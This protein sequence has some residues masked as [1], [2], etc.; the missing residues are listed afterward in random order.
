[1]HLDSRF[2]GNDRKQ[3]SDVISEKLQD[4]VVVSEEEEGDGGFF[5]F[6]EDSQSKADAEFPQVA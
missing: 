2:R 5:P 6:E 3:S 4:F 1:M